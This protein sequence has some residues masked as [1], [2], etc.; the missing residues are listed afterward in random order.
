[1]QVN[2]KLEFERVAKSKYQLSFY[3][4]Y[5]SMCLM[6]LSTCSDYLWSDIYVLGDYNVHCFSRVEI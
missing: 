4:Y 3:V 6:E 2:L 5:L 1:M